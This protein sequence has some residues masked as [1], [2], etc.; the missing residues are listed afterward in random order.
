MCGGK[1]GTET[2]SIGDN[3]TSILFEDFI[4]GPFDNSV[5]IL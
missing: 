2:A 4:D 3:Y 5:V 1:K